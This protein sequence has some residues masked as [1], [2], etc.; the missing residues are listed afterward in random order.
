MDAMRFGTNV[1]QIRE[2]LGLSQRQVAE[3]ADT[4]GA[5][6]SRIEA[7]LVSPSMDSACKIADALGVSLD[8]LLR[9]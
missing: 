6:I 2:V 3:R 9:V 8:R 7:G 4:T 1:K 5:T